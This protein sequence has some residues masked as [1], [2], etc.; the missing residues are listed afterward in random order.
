MV[1]KSLEHFG[2]PP[3]FEAEEKNENVSVVQQIRQHLWKFLDDL[4][5][6]VV[7]AADSALIIALVTMILRQNDNTTCFD[8]GSILTGDALLQQQTMLFN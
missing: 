8:L 2:K 5:T 3:R 1:S 7:I 4:Y 6:T